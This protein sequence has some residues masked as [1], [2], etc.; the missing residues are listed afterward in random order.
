[1]DKTLLILLGLLAA[2]GAAVLILLPGAP[3]TPATSGAAVVRTSA[4]L[5][6]V[7]GV[8]KP[9]EYSGKTVIGDVEVNWATEKNA[10]RVGLV[11]PGTGWVAIGFNPVSM[12]DKANIILGA[13]VNGAVVARDDVGTGPFTHA[14]DTSVGGQDNLLAAAGREADGKMAFEFAIPLN[15]GDATD[16]P[17]SIGQTVK[18]IV[19]YQTTSDDFAERHSRRASGEITLGTP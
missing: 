2:V 9:G 11:S 6:S 4:A 18:I 8:I 7:D 15:S 14:P 10:L 12:M 13:V 16:R 3:A 1:M 5:P 19:A 17:L